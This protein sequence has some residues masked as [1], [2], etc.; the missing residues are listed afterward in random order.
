MP[1]F[2]LLWLNDYDTLSPDNT[3]ITGQ[4]QTVFFPI[5][6]EAPF[7]IYAKTLLDYSMLPTKFDKDKNCSIIHT[8]MP[9]DFKF[10]HNVAIFPLFMV[11]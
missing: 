2:G 7:S 6:Y 5:T 10:L 1:T 8:I 4:K 9:S 3:P 11:F